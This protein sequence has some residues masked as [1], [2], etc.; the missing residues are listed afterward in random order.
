[1]YRK[2]LLVWLIIL[3]SL[4]SSLGLGDVSVPIG[5]ADAAINLTT[6]TSSLD[7]ISTTNAVEV[8]VS[9]AAEFEHQNYRTILGVV[10]PLILAEGVSGWKATFIIEHGGCFGIGSWE[11][12][13]QEVGP[14]VIC[15]ANATVSMEEFNLWVEA[16]GKGGLDP[17]L[18]IPLELSQTD[19]VEAGQ[20]NKQIWTNP[21]QVTA[22]IILRCGDSQFRKY[23]ELMFGE[24]ALSFEKWI[25]EAGQPQV[26]ISGE[27][28]VLSQDDETWKFIRAHCDDEQIL[29]EAT[30]DGLSS[31]FSGTSLFQGPSDPKTLSGQFRV[32]RDLVNAFEFQGSLGRK[33]AQKLNNILDQVTSSFLKGQVEKGGE[34]LG[35]FIAFVD[36]ASAKDLIDEQTAQSMVDQALIVQ[37]FIISVSTP[38]LVPPLPGPLSCPGDQGPCP[39]TLSSCEFTEFHVD[40]KAAGTPDGSQSHPF[41]SIIAALAQAAVIDVCGIELLV[42]RGVYSGDIHISRHTKISGQ[43]PHIFERVFIRGSVINAGPYSLEIRRVALFPFSSGAPQNGVVVSHLC[44]MTLLQDVFIHNFRGFGI[45]HRGGS[46]VLFRT[47]VSSTQAHTEFLSQG[48]GILLTCGV[49]AFMLSVRLNNNESSGLLMSGV[50]TYARAFNLRVTGTGVHPLLFDSDNLDGA[51]AWGAVHVRNGAR[52]EATGYNISRNLLVGIFIDSLGV[53]LLEA[54]I[55]ADTRSVSPP[56]PVGAGG[57]GAFAFR[58]GSLSMHYFDVIRNDIC[59]IYVA[60][61]GIDAGIIELFDGEVAENEI[62]ACVK[63]PGYP[64]SLLQN[65]VVYRDNVA[66]ID[67]SSLPVPMPSDV[68][69]AP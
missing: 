2:P 8:V 18:M 29:P 48:T 46:L 23:G 24:G 44:A 4:V 68:D 35:R 12:D 27:P 14:T 56:P 31:Q 10:S 60:S 52:L 32:L 26:N 41:P 16:R 40:D 34:R 55:I 66:N 37:D 33:Q 39:D 61:D 58:G 22:Q 5:T 19:V 3:V 69:I 42:A 15:I 17:N 65:R 59:G 54:G 28:V 53:A 43:E 9:L 36:Q 38:P 7:S 67:A 57:I 45:H 25:N 47:V 20:N 13:A 62:G 63:V 30:V 51:G 11:S 1:M 50:G 6:G 64:L 21:A 49:R